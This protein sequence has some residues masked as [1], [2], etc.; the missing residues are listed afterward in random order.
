MRILLV[1]H[2]QTTSNVA[3]ALDT[4]VPGAGLTD[5]GA[6]QADAAAA[7]LADLGVRS[8]HASTLER[9][10]LTARPLARRLGVDVRVDDGFREI[11]AGALEMRSDRDA[12]EEYAVGIFEWFGGNLDHAHHGGISGH[13]FLRRYDAA[14][15]EV[16]SSGVPVAAV[17][18]H[19]AAIRVWVGLRAENA[20][21]EYVGLPNTAAVTL[22]GDQ[23]RGW[24][25]VDFGQVP[26]GGEGL[27]ELDGFG[28]RQ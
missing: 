13:D 24:T 25:V 17:F 12:I 5:L 14:I 22:E 19:G 21:T 1:R 8:V 26:L 3:G 6:R 18:S 2:A 16:A 11:D 28:L 7:V 10:Q 27:L 15:G 23:A 20:P 9:T 4:A